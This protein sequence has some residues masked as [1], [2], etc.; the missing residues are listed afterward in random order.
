MYDFYTDLG[1]KLALG[2]QTVPQRGIEQAVV[3]QNSLHNCKL[4]TFGAVDQRVF[5]DYCHFC[6]NL[7]SH[8]C[9]FNTDIKIISTP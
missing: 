2:G 9:I 1:P 4:K 7:M 6:I 5:D 3:L 8:F